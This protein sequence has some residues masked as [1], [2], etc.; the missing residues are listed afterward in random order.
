MEHPK[1]FIVIN[2]KTG[3]IERQ[4]NI[5]PLKHELETWESTED[6][7]VQVKEQT[8]TAYEDMRYE[9]K[10]RLYNYIKYTKQGKVI[11]RYRP[12]AGTDIGKNTPIL[13]F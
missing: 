3:V 4:T 1:R 8:K 9:A 13:N 7:N 11:P 6:E 2:N 5:P 10:M 12:F